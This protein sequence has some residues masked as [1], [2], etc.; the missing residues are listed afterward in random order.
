MLIEKLKILGNSCPIIFSSSIQAT[1]DNPY[2]KSKKVGEELL[3]SYGKD[4]G[5]RIVILR[6]PNVFGKWCR[7]NYN[8]VIATLSYNIIHDLPITIHDPHHVMNLIYIDDL[9]DEMIKLIELDKY[10]YHDFTNIYTVT[11]QY[12]VDLMI[13]FKDSRENKRLP[14]LSEEFSRKLYST[15]ISYLPDVQLKYELMTNIDERGSFT[16]FIKG[17]TFGQLSVNRSKPGIIKGNHWHK[18]KHER[19]LVV[20]GEGVIRLR[21]INTSVVITIK[22][23]GEMLEVVDVPAGY[24]HNIENIGSSDMII[25][26]WANEIYDSSHPDTYYM[27]V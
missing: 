11:L 17:E 26:I 5:A 23:D 19:F 14:N 20:S 27:E 12:I 24:V 8:S 9:I 1:L 7:P 2:G 6:I 18:L 15:Y 10:G 13:T 16:E 25:L 22:V 4:T 3:L 21:K